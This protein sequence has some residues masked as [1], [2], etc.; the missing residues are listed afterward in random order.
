MA[1][2]KVT[3]YVVQYVQRTLAPPVEC[4]W[5]EF[6]SDWHMELKWSGSCVLMR[7]RNR[8]AASLPLLV[9]IDVSTQDIKVWN[10]LKVDR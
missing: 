3:R 4:L 1:S 7:S 8:L 9:D 6:P 5:A 10:A 2:K